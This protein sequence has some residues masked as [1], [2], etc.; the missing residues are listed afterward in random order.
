LEWALSAAAQNESDA[1]L[2][3]RAQAGEELAFQRLYDRHA[4]RAF[5]VALCICHDPGRAEDAVQEGF[6]SIWRGR[7]SYRSQAGSFQAWAM[8][9]VHNRALDSY[10]AVA[11][12]PPCQRRLHDEERTAALEDVTVS[13]SDQAITRAE[14][15]A[16]RALLAG[17]PRVQ[18]EVIVLAFYGGLSHSE[19]ATQLNLPPGTVKG[20]MRLGLEKLRRELAAPACAC[21][22]DRWR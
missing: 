12:R 17:L 11:A 13:P 2:M 5:R 22:P 16:L 19:I 20:R 18:A 14:G 4:G 15:E 7:A 3:A 1:V 8:K 9:I 6:L 10:R 21:R